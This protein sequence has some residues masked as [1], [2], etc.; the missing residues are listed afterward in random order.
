LK[1]FIH[2]TFK[3]GDRLPVTYHLIYHLSPPFYRP[4][5]LLF[6]SILPGILSYDSH[7]TLFFWF[8]I[9]VRQEKC[10]QNNRKL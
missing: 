8:Q 7:Q 5:L 4:D 10:W 6:P 2:S 9:W 3:H 1:Q